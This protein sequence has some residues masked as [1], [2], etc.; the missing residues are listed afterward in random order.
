MLL[1]TRNQTE[2]YSNRMTR[3]SQMEA[4]TFTLPSRAAS[5]LA[6][7]SPSSGGEEAASRR[8]QA[9][10]MMF[11][12]A[13]EAEHHPMHPN[14]LNQSGVRDAL[15]VDTRDAEQVLRKQRFQGRSIRRNGWG[16]CSTGMEIFPARTA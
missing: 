4:E 8:L 16:R 1:D 12:G 6:A 14:N 11:F 10:Y 2:P 15:F 9:Q 13:I 7:R 5:R 3:T